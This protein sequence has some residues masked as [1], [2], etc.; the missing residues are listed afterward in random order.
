MS[1][2]QVSN[3]LSIDGRGQYSMVFLRSGCLFFQIL[4]T[5]A[6]PS[7]AIHEQVGFQ[8]SLEVGRD[9]RRKPHTNAKSST[10]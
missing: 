9:S 10:P 1:D 3:C 2:A 4:C 8:I 6:A 5:H 7:A